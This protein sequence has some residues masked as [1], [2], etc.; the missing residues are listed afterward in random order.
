MNLPEETGKKFINA[1]FK[2][3]KY[4]RFY[5]TGD[6]GYKLSDGNIMFSGR[7]D[8]QI[9]FRGYRIELEEIEKAINKISGIKESCVLLKKISLDTSTLIAYYSSDLLNENQVKSTL[10]QLSLY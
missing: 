2:D 1:V 4:E 7:K 10:K 9:K 6:F 3:C 8:N 5:K